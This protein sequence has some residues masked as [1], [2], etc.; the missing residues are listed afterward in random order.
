MSLIAPLIEPA[1]STPDAGGAR[2]RSQVRAIGMDGRCSITIVIID[3]TIIPEISRTHVKFLSPVLS[4]ELIYLLGVSKFALVVECTNNSQ[5]I[6]SYPQHRKVPILA[7]DPDPRPNPLPDPAKDAP[8]APFIY[9]TA[10]PAFG[11]TKEGDISITLAARRVMPGPNDK[12][13][14]DHVVVAH[15]CG[16]IEAATSLKQALDKTLL[17]VAPA[18]GETAN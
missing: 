17:A 7:N 10:A 18:A 16:N 8:H 9:F 1:A 11:A 6:F 14:I 12:A 4:R 15:L 2:Y 5:P 13:I 3:G